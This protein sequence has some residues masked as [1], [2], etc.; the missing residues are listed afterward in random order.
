LDPAGVVLTAM[1][2]LLGAA[3]GSFLN[4]V[5][6][7]LPRRESVVWPGSHCPLC[8][9]DIRW[10]H[11]LPVLGWLLLRGRCHDCGERISLRYPLVELLTAVL[12]AIA[13]VIE[14]PQPSVLLLWFFLAVLVAVTF[15]DIDHLIIPDR[16]VLPAALVGFVGATALAPG[17]WWEFL[18]AAIAAAGFLLLLG[19]LWPGGM[20]FGDVKL[21]LVM[22]AVLGHVVAIALF[23]SFLLGGVVGGVLLLTGIKGRKDKIPFGPY[24]AAGS[25]IAAL[26]GEALLKAYLSLYA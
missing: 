3:V 1:A 11:N 9:H 5:I 17:R 20:G 2:A 25:V 10:Y 15:I 7:R 16:I 23:L 6:H 4:V 24:L 13:L 26:A 8:G 19:L 12:F 22:G 18:I 21:A 14:G